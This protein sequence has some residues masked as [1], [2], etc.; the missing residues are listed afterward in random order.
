MRRF[1]LVV[2]GA[3]PA[4]MAAATLAEKNGASVALLDEQPRLGGQIYR[5]ITDTTVK[6]MDILGSDYAAGK[7]LTEE[8]SAGKITH[9]SLATVWDVTPDGCVTFTV[10]GLVD[11]VEGRF[12]LLATGALERPVP[13][14]GWTLPG[15][16]TAGAAQIL[17][18]SS[19]I[20]ST[21]A[22][23][24]GSGPLIYL[25]A[26]QMIAAGA[27]PLAIVETQ[28][29]QNHIRSLRHLGGA[30]RGHNVIFKGISLLRALRRAGVKRYTSVEMIE[31]LGEA[32]VN[33]IRVTRSGHS[34][35]ISCDTVFLHQGVVPNTQISRALRLDHAW[36]E[37]QRCF[38]PV[39][40]QWGRTENEQ[41]FIA[42]DGAG[43]GGAK[44][45]EL[46][47]NLSAIEILYLLGRLDEKSRDKLARPV[48]KAIG[49]EQAIRP[50]LDTLYS[51]P[52]FCARPADPVLIC[53]C[54][55]VTA[56]DIRK[57][58]KLGCTGPNQT[59]AFGRSGMGPCQGRYCGIT[60]TEILAQENG[61]KPEQIGSYR[62]RMP[63][64]PVTLGEVASSATI[65]QN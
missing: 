12:L 40:D 26:A 65:K 56:G 53:R 41:I 43:I 28:T 1:D 4:G 20:V 13:V 39:T 55:E 51:V 31:V 5:N 23:L 16:M 30:I 46:A 61:A 27:P 49:K 21:R 50:F 54:E 17:M 45:A 9:I 58:A 14:P 35:D 32:Q 19:G 18:K 47:G 7:R 52:D 2:I 24:A 57:L 37:V 11:R 6:L 48:F 15:V 64:K 42:G 62:I 22:V 25:V 8:F 44:A 34:E 63:V 60:V 36:S 10:N 3:G 29:R 38:R 59:K 33:G